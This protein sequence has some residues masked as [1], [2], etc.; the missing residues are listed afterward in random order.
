[1]EIIEKLLLVENRD[2]L[3][4]QCKFL[5][6]ENYADI[7]FQN[8]SFR[9]FVVSHSDILN[10]YEIKCNDKRIKDIVDDII[11]ALCDKEG[12]FGLSM[13]RIEKLSN[14]T[15]TTYYS[16]YEMTGITI[17]RDGAVVILSDEQMVWKITVD[18]LNQILTDSIKENRRITNQS[19]DKELYQRE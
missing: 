4:V 15:N 5:S 17:R 2:L 9:Q 10:D 3:S 18:D 1:M 16:E 8:D 19:N 11:T 14:K 6:S 12:N 7:M 13:I